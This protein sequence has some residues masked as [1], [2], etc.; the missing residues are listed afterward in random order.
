M[1]L[2]LV[3]AKTF[4]PIAPNIFAVILPIPLPA[5][6]KITDLFFNESI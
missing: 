4:A 3:D 5:P 1:F 2:L 6:V